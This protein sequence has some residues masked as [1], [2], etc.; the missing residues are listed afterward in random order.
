MEPNLSSDR[1]LFWLAGILEGEGT[2]D[3]HRGRY[4]RVRVGMTDRDVVGRAATL[5][6]ANVRL[7]LRE[8][9]N[10][11]TWHA[12]V[13]GPKAVLIME[14]LLP[15]MG[16]RRSGKIAEILAAYRFARE[17]DPFR[18]S[19]P[20]PATSQPPGIVRASGALNKIGA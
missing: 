20:G 18:T 5:M 11:P 1:D 4:P 10:Q 17:K 16:S 6:G 2:F 19:I 15:H 8:A 14:A 3:L 7:A 12:E 9:P 13:S